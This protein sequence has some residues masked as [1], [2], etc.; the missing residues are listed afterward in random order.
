MLRHGVGITPPLNRDVRRKSRNSASEVTA[1]PYHRSHLDRSS[2]RSS[3]CLRESRTARICPHWPGRATDRELRAATE[4]SRSGSDYAVK[5]ENM[6]S[7]Y[8]V[9]GRGRLLHERC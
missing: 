1:M 4:K 2:G 6:T 5:L 8:D 3:D 7:F 9:A